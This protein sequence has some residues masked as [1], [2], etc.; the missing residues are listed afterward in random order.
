MLNGNVSEWNISCTDALSATIVL[1]EDCMLCRVLAEIS[2]VLGEK[3]EVTSKQLEELKY[4]EQV[5]A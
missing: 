2:E 4:L 3:Q 5:Y 1:I